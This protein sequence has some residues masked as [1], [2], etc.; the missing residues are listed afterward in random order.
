MYDVVCHG[1]Q[2]C[3]QLHVYM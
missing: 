2:K 3:T 1:W